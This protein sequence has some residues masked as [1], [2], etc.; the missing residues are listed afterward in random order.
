M[1]SYIH[2]IYDIVYMQVQTKLCPSTE[3]VMPE[4]ERVYTNLKRFLLLLLLYYVIL[5]SAFPVTRP[6]FFKFY[7][8]AGDVIY[9]YLVFLVTGNVGHNLACLLYFTG[10]YTF[11]CLSAANS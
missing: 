11:L 5:L 8:W 10:L 3:L 9:L 6:K 4:G 2:L 1:K 7:I